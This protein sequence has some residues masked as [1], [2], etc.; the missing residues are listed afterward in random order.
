MPPPTPSPTTSPFLGIHNM[1]KAC[2]PATRMKVLVVTL[3]ATT[4]VETPQ[5]RAEKVFQGIKT[6]LEQSDLDI[7]II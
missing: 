4:G 5:A 7:A 2:M 6:S 3:V 1:Y